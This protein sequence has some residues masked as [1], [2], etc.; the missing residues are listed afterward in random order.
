MLTHTGWPAAERLDSERLILQPLTLEHAQPMVAV[1]A[2]A[3]LYSF[4]GGE[5]PTLGQ[6][7][8]RYAAQ[9]V[10]GPSDGTQRWLNWIVEP[11]GADAPVGFVQATVRAHPDGAVADLAWLIGCANQGQGLA[12]EATGTMMLYLRAQGIA[13][14]AAFIHPDHEASNAVARRQGLRPTGQLHDGEI[15]WESRAPREAQP[16]A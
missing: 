6:L 10:G 4:T 11:R 2:D 9:A 15:R 13:T 1:L 8:K 5:P 3:A 14:F 16:E 7:Q 12:S